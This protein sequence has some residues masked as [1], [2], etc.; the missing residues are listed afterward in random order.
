[1]TRQLSSIQV[2]TYGNNASEY[3]IQFGIVRLKE[4]TWIPNPSSD[5]HESCIQV[6][7]CAV[8]SIKI[9]LTKH[10][11]RLWYCDWSACDNLDGVE[12]LGIVSGRRTSQPN[13]PRYKRFQL[14]SSRILFRGR[15]LGSRYPAT[16]KIKTQMTS[17]SDLIDVLLFQG[18]SKSVCPFTRWGLDTR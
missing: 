12:M 2:V 4:N 7:D 3:V 11:S 6:A 14:G 1:M 8:R 9:P 16:G 18:S 13:L 17:I 10:L 15:R 5:L